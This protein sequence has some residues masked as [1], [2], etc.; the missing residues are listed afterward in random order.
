VK[1]RLKNSHAGHFLEKG[2]SWRAQ[3]A[4]RNAPVTLIDKTTPIQRY[5]T[6]LSRDSIATQ[7]VIMET[8]R[9]QKSSFTMNN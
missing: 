1:G 7:T 2:F 5:H 6:I 3:V 9:K 4:E 8:F